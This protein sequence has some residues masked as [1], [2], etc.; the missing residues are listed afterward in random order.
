MM[1]GV[2]AAGHDVLGGIGVDEDGAAALAQDGPAEALPGPP[3]RLSVAEL[4]QLLKKQE[5]AAS[6]ARKEAKK[7]TWP[8]INIWILHMYFE[9][10]SCKSDSLQFQAVSYGATV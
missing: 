9:A 7:V 1:T 10:H 4:K 8:W 6:K 2:A 5:K 3:P